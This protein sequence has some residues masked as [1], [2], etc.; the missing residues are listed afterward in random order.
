MVRLQVRECQAA[1]VV[2]AMIPV[3]VLADYLALPETRFLIAHWPAILV[4]LAL[5]GGLLEW[6]RRRGPA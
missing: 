4:A 1:S 3:A 2:R 5:Y 6:K